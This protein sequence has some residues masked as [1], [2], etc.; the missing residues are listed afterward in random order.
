MPTPS[1]VAFGFAE[2]LLPAV[3]EGANVPPLS[4]PAI[5]YSASALLASFKKARNRG[6]RGHAGVNFFPRTGKAGAPAGLR[7]LLIQ[8]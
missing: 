3:E 7:L 4:R 5:A 8:N 2:K 1:R 6:K